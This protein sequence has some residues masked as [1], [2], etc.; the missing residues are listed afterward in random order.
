MRIVLNSSRMMTTNRMLLKIS[1]LLCRNGSTF[2]TLAC[3][4]AIAQVADVPAPA[5]S[6]PASASAPNGAVSFASIS[7][8]ND[9]LAKLEQSAT[10]AGADLSRL[11]VE[12]WKADNETKRQA[13]LNANSLVKNLQSAL[14]GMIS[15]LRANPEDLP[16]NFKLYRNLTALYDVM[17]QVTELTGAFGAKN[18]YQSL[19]DDFNAL[20]ALRRQFADRME[21][22]VAA[23]Q[24]E[25]AHLRELV[26]AAQDAVANQPVKKVIVDDNAVVPVAVPV[27]KKSKAAKAVPKPK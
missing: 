24:G 1:R 2:A 18:E 26:V 5:V 8:L 9:L 25:I 17:A 16:A 21:A 14:P 3:S 13:Q 22:L 11:K 27:K 4:S 6:N 23:K 12:K 7:A 20:E 19:S 10:V 15:E